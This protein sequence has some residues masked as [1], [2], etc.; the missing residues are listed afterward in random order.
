MV[1]W[2][3]FIGCHFA[4]CNL[5]WVENCIGQLDG[6]WQTESHLWTRTCTFA[7]Q[8]TWEHLHTTIL[9]KWQHNLRW[10]Q[11]L[12]TELG[13]HGFF[14]NVSDEGFL[15]CC[16]S[17]SWFHVRASKIIIFIASVEFLCKLAETSVLGRRRSIFE[18]L[19]TFFSLDRN[20]VSENVLSC[21][22]GYRW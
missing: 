16:Q 13:L 15:C 22:L 17:Y 14:F 4:I 19:V 10:S 7:F 8:M 3:N 18:W 6:S 5:S 9:M 12:A 11:L 2:W 1:S 21:Q 20:F